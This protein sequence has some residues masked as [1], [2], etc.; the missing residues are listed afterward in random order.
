MTTEF[1]L[2]SG[3]WGNCFEQVEAA[4]TALRPQEPRVS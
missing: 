3:V 2:V 4:A 1:T